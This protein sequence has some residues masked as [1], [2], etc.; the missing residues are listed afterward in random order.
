MQIN[1]AQWNAIN[2]SF[3]LCI[4]ACFASICKLISNFLIPYI[5][6][7]FWIFLWTAYNILLVPSIINKLSKIFGTFISYLYESHDYI[8]FRKITLWTFW[9]FHATPNGFTWW[10]SNLC[11]WRSVVPHGWLIPKNFFSW[12]QEVNSQ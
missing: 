6:S 4:G 8:L 11:C 10:L 7:A 1:C 2:Y 9:K 3:L 12:L 5:C